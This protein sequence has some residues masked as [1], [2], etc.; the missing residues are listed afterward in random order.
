MIARYAS[1]F[2]RWAESRGQFLTRMLMVVAVLTAPG[3]APDS[4]PQPIAPPPSMVGFSFSPKAVP[5]PHLDPQVA[6]RQLLVQLHPDLVRLPVYWDQAEPLPGRLDF[7]QADAMLRT[8]DEYNLT[9]QGPP[10]RVVLVIG[11]R[12]LGSPEA[13][14]PTWALASQGRLGKLTQ[15]LAY[16]SYLRGAVS[17]FASSPLLFA[18]QLENEPLDNTNPWLGDVAL[19]AEVLDREIGNLKE[20]DNRHPVVVTTFDSATLSLDLM[21]DSRLSWLWKML[22]GP[23]PAGHPQ[24]ALG[25]GDVLGLDAYVVTPNTPLSETGAEERI[26]WKRDALGYWSRQASHQGKQLWITEMQ[27]A[28]WDG[29]SGFTQAELMHSAQGYRNSGASVVLLWGVESWLTHPDWMAHGKK[30]INV[31]RGVAPIEP[32]V[33]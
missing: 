9:A 28:P 27:G 23:R 25:L 12:N 15:T 5:D 18:W 19:P 33:A 1:W 21:A 29:V 6:L 17:H 32:I 10:A 16:Q 8:I 13:H 2:Y 31:I 22:P 20:I 7:S 24:S 14:V 11:A 26:A 4:S 3:A 30:A